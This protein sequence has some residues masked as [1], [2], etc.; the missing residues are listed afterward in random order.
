LFLPQT[1]RCLRGCDPLSDLRLLFLFLRDRPQAG[2]GVSRRSTR[3]CFCASQSALAS[4]RG[5]PSPA[6]LQSPQRCAM[7]HARYSLTDTPMQLYYCG[8][9]R[10][11]S[12]DTSVPKIWVKGRRHRNVERAKLGQRAAYLS[13]QYPCGIGKIHATILSALL[14]RQRM[15]CSYSVCFSTVHT[16]TYGANIWLT[17]HFALQLSTATH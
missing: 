9:R 15:L 14:I 10:T 5:I 3:I 16:V 2:L 17:L 1:F 13:C 11:V 6:S 8:R 4:A 7:P 12:N